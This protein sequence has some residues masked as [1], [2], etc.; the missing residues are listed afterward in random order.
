MPL[1][2]RPSGYK[3]INATLLKKY[4]ETVVSLKI[5]HNFFKYLF[6]S[7]LMNCCVVSES[8]LFSTEVQL[9]YG[10]WSSAKYLAKILNGKGT[11]F[12]TPDLISEF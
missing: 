9:V 2:A 6:H 1:R 7:T 10:L 8:N 11:K 3:T 4:S 5:L 12:L